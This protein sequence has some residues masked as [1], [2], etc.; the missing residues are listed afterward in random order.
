M[1]HAYVEPRRELRLAA[2]LSAA[3]AALLWAGPYLLRGD[4]FAND[5][6]QH[7]FWLYRYADPAL[8]PGDLSARFFS[9]LSSAPWGYRALYALIAPWADVLWMAKLLAGGLMLLSAWLAWRLAAAIAPREHVELA[10]LVGAAAALWLIAQTADVMTPLA[11][12]R[13][14]AFPIVLLLL[15]ALVAR[16][17]FWVGA[18]WLLAALFYPV[19]LVV[20]GIGGAGCL[21][22]EGVRERRLPLLWTW[23]LLA[24]L[25]AVGIVILC[26]RIPQDL[27]PQISGQ[28]ALAMPEFGMHG[29]LRLF[30]GTPVGDWVRSQLVGL[31]W[32][33]GPLAVIA[34]A[35]MIVVMHRRV[36]LPRAAWMLLISG[37]AVWAVARLTL[38][39]LYLPNRHARWAI[40]GF[41]VAALVCCGVVLFE[42]VTARVTARSAGILA[43]LAGLAAL[44]VVVSA[45][46]GPASRLWHRPVDADLERAY[47]Y[48]ASL[49]RDTLIAAH[50]D[51]ADFVPLRA[52]RSVLASTETALPFMQGYYARV[53]PRLIAS[54]RAAYAT[55]WTDLDRTLTPY[56]ASVVLTAPQVWSAASYY[57]PFD[58][59][60][61]QLRARGRLQGFVLQHP[62]PARV[63]FRSGEVY[64]VRAGAPYVSGGAR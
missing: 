62:D 3:V 33:L 46:A 25:A 35:T 58:G 17:Y 40:A 23:N 1:A 14:F 45:F 52:R 31:G 4:L 41:A 2:V 38:F 53:R 42:W 44:A 57:E 22:W 60:V 39:T 24:G 32:S 30:V 36:R 61:A 8:F 26:A 13:S 6:T 11:L 29:R 49:P 34:L 55:N 7:I 12:Q 51:L 18:A 28:D 43:R 59:L 21:A 10:G 9:L 15:W 48:L 37:V 5:A 20:L 64:I 56:G 47:L 16:Q 63:L 27:G 50:P 54:L 19:I